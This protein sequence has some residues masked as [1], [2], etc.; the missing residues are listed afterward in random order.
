VTETVVLTM[1]LPTDTGE[2]VAL[3]DALETLTLGG[4]DNVHELD[5]FRE[6]IGNREDVTELGITGEIGI[7]LDDLLL[8]G[9]P[10]LFEMALQS[11]AGLLLFLFVIGKLNGG[12]PIGLDRANLRDNTRTSFNDGAWNILSISTEDGNHSDFLS[13]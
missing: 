8:G 10:C 12:V 7:E 11:L 3:H 6:D 2:S 5:I 4:T 9:G 1:G 13:N